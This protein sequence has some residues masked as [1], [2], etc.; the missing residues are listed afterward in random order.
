MRHSRSTFG[1]I[2][3]RKSCRY[4]ERSSISTT[5]T[6]NASAARNECEHP[7]RYIDL[8]AGP[9][10]KNAQS[11]QPGKDPGDGT[12]GARERRAGAHS[13]GNSAGAS[14]RDQDAGPI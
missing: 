13:R 10:T 12:C 9:P 7:R 8:V 6:T 3:S 4:L 14:L 11:E 1:G 2:S 5:T